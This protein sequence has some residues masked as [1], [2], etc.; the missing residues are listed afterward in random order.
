MMAS[1]PPSTR[2]FTQP[3]SVGISH[4]PDTLVGAVESCLFSLVCSARLDRASPSHRLC[5]WGLMAEAGAGVKC[6]FIKRDS[7]Y[8]GTS[9]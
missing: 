5:S 2:P 6:T 7:K 1:V 9:H 4:I 3:V 8:A